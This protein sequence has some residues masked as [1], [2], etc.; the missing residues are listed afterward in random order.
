[1]VKVKICGIT[2]EA[3]LKA[4]EALGADALGFVV[5]APS[6]QRNLQLS[7][8]KSL[9]GK[10]SKRV[11]TVAVTVF[12]DAKRLKQI[13]TETKAD[14]LQLHGNLHKVTLDPSLRKRI[15]GVVDAR[16]KDAV[17][18]AVV[19]SGIFTSVLA[20]TAGDGGVGGTGVTHNWDLS[21]RIRD[22]IYPVPLILAGGLSAENVGEAIRRVR[23]YGVDVSSGVERRPR[24]KDH[25]KMVEFVA[26]AKEARGDE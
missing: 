9:I 13:F 25:K 3:D 16:A 22:A 12:K 19:Y 20:D 23:P 11:N 6:S 5:D 10:A 17:E 14:Y 15:I 4:A 1:M 24:I 8:A 2:R 18:R 21:K 26:K 7:A